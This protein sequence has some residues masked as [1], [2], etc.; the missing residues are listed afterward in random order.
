MFATKQ[1]TIV[2]DIH[3][4]QSSTPINFGGIPNLELESGTT[5]APGHII[6]QDG[7]K[8]DLQFGRASLPS[9]GPTFGAGEF[10]DNMTWWQTTS[11]YEV[12]GQASYQLNL[13]DMDPFKGDE[14]GS[15]IQP[16]YATS[17][18]MFQVSLNCGH[19][20]HPYYMRCNRFQFY[21]K[22]GSSGSWS[23]QFY[24]MSSSLYNELY[25]GSSITI[26]GGVLMP[27][28]N[29]TEKVY[30]QMKHH[31][32]DKGHELHLNQSRE[33]DSDISLNSFN[34][35]SWIMLREVAG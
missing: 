23:S 10:I 19:E 7:E 25:D 2:P 28:L 26:Q 27:S 3:G 12:T 16:K 14:N 6:Q 29:T 22:I 20:Y 30:F 35:I 13:V 32:H 9:S 31:G 11:V 18:I 4:E 8:F 5:G 17:R 24:S 34:H 21:Y 1:T 33:G 15:W